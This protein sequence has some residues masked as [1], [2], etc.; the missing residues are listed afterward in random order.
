MKVTRLS[1]LSDLLGFMVLACPDR[2]PK[3]GAYGDDSAANLDI[4]FGRLREGMALLDKRL[5][6]RE[7]QEVDRLVDSAFEAYQRGDRKAGAHLLQDVEDIAF[8]KRFAEHAV[9][10]NEPI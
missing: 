7:R 9:K 5:P 8:P 3:V 1:D 10:K 2:F 4:A 6:L